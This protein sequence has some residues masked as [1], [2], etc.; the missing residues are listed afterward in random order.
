MN[1]TDPPQIRTSPQD[2]RGKRVTI[3][4]HGLDQD[5]VGYFLAGLADQLGGILP[6]LRRSPRRT[7]P[8]TRKPTATFRALG[9][10][11][12]ANGTA[13]DQAVRVL[14]QALAAGRLVDRHPV[15]DLLLTHDPTNAASASTSVP[16]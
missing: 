10:S 4:L 2:L 15:R 16:G 3:R 12:K 7:R 14:N 6:G 5:A 9:A 8:D 11:G 1:R 13:T